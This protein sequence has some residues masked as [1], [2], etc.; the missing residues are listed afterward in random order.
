MSMKCPKC[1]QEAKEIDL[2]NGIVTYSCGTVRSFYE[3]I[4]SEQ[5]KRNQGVK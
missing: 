2:D 5:C 3:I 4:E 1:K